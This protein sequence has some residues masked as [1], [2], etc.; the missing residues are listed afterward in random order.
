[1]AGGRFYISNSGGTLE[2]HTLLSVSRRWRTD[3]ARREVPNRPEGEIVDTDIWISRLEQYT[4][5]LR[6]KDEELATLDQIF[7]ASQ[8]TKKVVV[9]IGEDGSDEFM[10]INGWIL[11]KRERWEY[12][13]IDGEVRPWRVELRVIGRVSG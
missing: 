12:R 5:V 9:K 10:Q 1:M 11:E 8:G 6:L 4:F 3:V 2:V 13:I 7:V